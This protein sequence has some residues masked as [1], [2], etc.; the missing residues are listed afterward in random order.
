MTAEEKRSRPRPVAPSL[1][2]FITPAEIEIELAIEP[3]GTMAI[4]MAAGRPL[5]TS[6]QNPNQTKAI[7]GRDAKLL[8]RWLCRGLMFVFC[9]KRLPSKTLPRK[10]KPAPRPIPFTP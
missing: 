10:L 4:G 8:L 5:V 3:D 9:R 6:E 1:D 2:P 7:L